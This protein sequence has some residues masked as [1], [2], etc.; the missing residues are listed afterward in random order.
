MKTIAVANNKGGVGKSTVAV[1]L[2]VGLARKGKRV[3]ILDLDALCRIRH[4]LSYP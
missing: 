4:K 2:A 3:L 1:S